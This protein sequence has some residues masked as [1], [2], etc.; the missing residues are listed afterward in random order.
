M[1]TQDVS[2]RARARTVVGLAVGVG[3][4]L[5]TAAGL[6][7][8]GSTVAAAAA[9]G[10]P[11]VLD[12]MDPV[13]H[14]TMGEST[15]GYIAEVLKG[16]QG[17]A[18]NANDGS[19][20]VVG[21]TES[22]NSCGG[23]IGSK[24]P[25]FLS[26]ITPTPTVAYYTDP[27]VL[28]AGIADGSLKPAVVWVPDPVSGNTSVQ[29]KLTS[30]ADNIADFV[31]N[32]GGL[33]SNMGQYGWLSALLPTARYNSGGCNGGPAVTTAGQTAFPGLTNS[34]VEACWHGYFTGD[35]GSLVPL[36]DWP[37]PN[38][39][40]PAVAVSIGGGSVS[41]PKNFDLQA[42][43]T[44]AETGTTRVFTAVLKDNSGSPR[45]GV[46][47]TFTVTSGP[48]AGRTQTAVT[49]ADGKAT[50]TVVGSGAGTDVVTLTGT[51]GGTLRTA[52]VEQ[53][54]TAAPAPVVAPAPPAPVAALAPVVVPAP[55]PKPVAAPVVTPPAAPAIGG[56]QTGNGK[57]VVTVVP[58]ASN[59]GSPVTGYTV[60]A[61]P[62]N[63]TVTL[64]AEGGAATIPGLKNG[65]AY[66]LVVTATNTAG[67]S[68]TSTAAVATPLTVAG[69]AKV[70]VAA[71]TDSAVA[72]RIAGPANDGGSDVTG[73]VVTL[74]DDEGN[75][76]T[77][78]VGAAGGVVPLKGLKAGTT[79]KVSVV[80]LNAAGSSPVAQVTL[81][82]PAKKPVAIDMAKGDKAV[83]IPGSSLV[84]TGDALFQ[85]QSGKLTPAGLRAVKAAAAG[86]EGAKRLRCDG[87]TDG[88]DT[89]ANR[90]L[91]L[92]RAQA[93]CAELKRQGVDAATSVKSYGGTHHVV[94]GGTR[95]DRAPN[96]RVVVTVVA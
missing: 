41:L 72:V 38:P 59:G 18:R 3:A 45:V 51:I 92:K 20:A 58:P 15:D 12:G 83:L 76:R 43:P 63:H 67:V 29:T 55:A 75:Q 37:Y 90:A 13:C 23:T 1:K 50:F 48:N 56:V 68:T 4:S 11:V 46:T 95:E 9:S 81:S 79:Y 33:F 53:V 60:T 28:F 22:S 8:G 84:L 24:M 66:T 74:T 47:V 96:R 44:S 31:N 49:D 6:S 27:D 42:D 69:T 73:Y 64:G 10:G 2:R 7:F 70:T 21:M 26:R 36:V 89:A 54:W 86:L 19:I 80:A 91:G 82:V 65:T 34:L 32:G 93:V 39:L 85:Y 78:K 16:L 87:Y 57:L 52:T 5:V 14:A 35:T 77:V 25:A 40:D 17:Q 71:K 62:G 61:Q 94:K 30:N 88:G